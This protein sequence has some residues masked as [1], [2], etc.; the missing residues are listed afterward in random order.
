MLTDLSFLSI[1]GRFPPIKEL[2]RLSRYEANKKLFEGAHEQV[3]RDWI[4]ILRQDQSAVLHL[5]FNFHRRLSTL[6]ADLLFGNPPIFMPMEEDEAQKF[7]LERILVENNFINTAYEV[8]LDVSRYGT[9]IFKVRYDGRAIIEGQ[10]PSFWF[11][12]VNPLNRKEIVAH[13]LAWHTENTLDTIWGKKNVQ[14]VVAEI[15][16]KGRITILQS[17]GENYQIG[18]ITSKEV[19][20]TGIDDFL[21]VPVHNISTTDGIYGLDDYADIDPIVQEIEVRMAQI[22]RILDKHADPN[23]YGPATALEIDPS[24]GQY[25]VRGGGQY[26]PLDSGDEP[27]GY[28]TWNGQLEA[29]FRQIDYLLDQLFAVSET[30]PRVFGLDKS[31]ITS[32][33]A[34]KTSMM[35][36]LS[37]VQ[38]LRLRFDPAIKKV[39]TL[40]SQLEA[41]NGRQGSV[42]VPSVNII[43]K[44]G[45]PRDEREQ[46]ITYATLVQNG[47]VSRR[48]AVKSLFGLEGEALERELQEIAGTSSQNIE[49]KALGL[50]RESSDL[51]KP[52]SDIRQSLA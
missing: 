21:V 28:I 12:V 11:P 45:F 13:V 33:L 31:A 25:V 19:I 41:Q 38:R 16:E 37:K 1:G 18:K 52:D 24:T 7:T 5:V 4:R 10:P 22:S 30:V 43:W 3:F 32:T 39:L 44:D 15:H 47:L 27:P 35:S 17:E 8:A 2:E 50:T 48:N 34:L 14:R 36:V 49:Q 26:F 40:A 42:V 29:A 9:G 23:M 51:D 46:A 6:W 20:E